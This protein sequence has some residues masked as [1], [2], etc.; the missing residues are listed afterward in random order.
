MGDTA[1]CP[2]RGAARSDALQTRDRQ[3]PC[4]SR[5]R[6]VAVHRANARCTASGTRIRQLSS[7]DRR[8]SGRSRFRFVVR[9]YLR[10]QQPHMAHHKRLRL[11]HVA[12][13]LGR[14]CLLP[15]RAVLFDYQRFLRAQVPLSVGHSGLG[16]IQHLEHEIS[17]VRPHVENITYP[18]GVGFPSQG[19]PLGTVSDRVR[20]RV[21]EPTDRPGRRF[22]SG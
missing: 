17:T 21:P 9:L 13:K 1:M 5:S 14:L 19:H 12:K 10:L 7:S 4:F 11:T 18:N 22:R 2:G 6:I 20:S 15:A 3:A 8:R 16:L